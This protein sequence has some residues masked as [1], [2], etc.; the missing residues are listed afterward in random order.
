MTGTSAG[1]RVT[2]S[3]LLGVA[4]VRA[5]RVTIACI[6][7]ALTDVASPNEDMMLLHTTNTAAV[8]EGKAISTDISGNP[9]GF[10]LC[11]IIVMS[12]GSRQGV[13][14]S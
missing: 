10:A 13:A 11:F 4:N 14:E 5:N 8:D 9:L 2:I 3:D 6:M 7:R 1:K 12:R